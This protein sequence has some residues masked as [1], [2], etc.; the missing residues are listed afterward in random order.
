MNVFGIKTLKIT[1]EDWDYIANNR[2]YLQKEILKIA[3]IAKKSKM[4]PPDPRTLLG[5]AFLMF[6]D[7]NLKFEIV[8]DY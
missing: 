5:K 3:K 1:E 6:T 7:E 2:E 4:G 8:A